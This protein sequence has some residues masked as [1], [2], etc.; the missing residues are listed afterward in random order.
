MKISRLRKGKFN[1]ISTIRS[2]K[3]FIQKRRIFMNL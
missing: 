3:I 1:I 2:K